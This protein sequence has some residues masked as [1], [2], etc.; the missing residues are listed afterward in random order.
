MRLC[1]KAAGTGA[2]FLER[3]RGRTNFATRRADDSIF[4][5]EEAAKFADTCE[6][7]CKCGCN[8]AF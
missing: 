2:F 4:D 6:R 3:H 1:A 5:E 7:T 8:R